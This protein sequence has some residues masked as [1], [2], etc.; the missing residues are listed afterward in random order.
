LRRELP[1][2]GAPR[3]N[4][5]FEEVSFADGST[6]DVSV[7]GLFGGRPQHI[8]TAW[9]MWALLDMTKAGRHPDMGPK[10]HY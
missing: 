10:L 4:Y 1:A 7:S 9:P 2:G 3:E 5:V 6:T 8:D